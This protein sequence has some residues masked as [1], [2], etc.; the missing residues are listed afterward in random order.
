MGRGRA[1]PCRVSTKLRSASVAFVAEPRLDRVAAGLAGE[2][3]GLL[4]SGEGSL[5]ELDDDGNLSLRALHLQERGSRVDPAA[6]GV[7]GTPSKQSPP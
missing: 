1:A 5:A 6:S 2:I 7:A 4:V 3:G